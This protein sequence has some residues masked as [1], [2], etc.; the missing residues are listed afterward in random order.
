[1]D[2]TCTKLLPKIYFFQQL[3]YSGDQISLT[4][5]I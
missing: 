1:M 2:K 4:D 3:K 5:D